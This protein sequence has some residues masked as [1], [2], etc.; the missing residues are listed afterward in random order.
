[1]A[2][3]TTKTGTCKPIPYPA[4]YHLYSLNRN[5][6]KRIAKSAPL[7]MDGLMKVW[8]DD[9]EKNFVSLIFVFSSDSGLMILIGIAVGMNKGHV[10]R[11]REIAPRPSRR[12]GALS[13]K[14]KA[15]RSLIKEVCGY[16]PPCPRYSYISKSCYLA[17]SLQDIFV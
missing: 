8:P 4:P 14:T 15:V 3:T 6:S 12:R 9:L 1:M 17:C 7:M 5:P 2:A 13:T 10:T 16:H 11:R